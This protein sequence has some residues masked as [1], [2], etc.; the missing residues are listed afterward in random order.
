MRMT[1]IGHSLTYVTSTLSRH[2]NS[3]NHHH[4][5]YALW[6]LLEDSGDGGWSVGT[7]FSANTT[8]FLRRPS[9]VS[10]LH[11]SHS[12]QNKYKKQ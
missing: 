7:S 9:L 6:N 8:Y 5:R 10:S 11:L 3:Q 12:E 2:L 1:V 4:G